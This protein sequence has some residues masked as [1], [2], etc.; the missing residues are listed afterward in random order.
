MCL[1]FLFFRFSFFG[2]SIA[3]A[4]EQFCRVL[5]TRPTSTA[6]NFS[7]FVQSLIYVLGVCVLLVFSFVA[8]IAIR[9]YFRV[10]NNYTATV[11]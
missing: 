6:L 10:S 4:V 5:Y 2:W 7:S 11:I 1:S 3:S 9:L 8:A